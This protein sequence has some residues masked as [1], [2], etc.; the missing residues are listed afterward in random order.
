MLLIAFH[1]PVP[2]N[3]TLGKIPLT[4]TKK[5]MLFSLTTLWF[6]NHCVPSSKCLYIHSVGTITSPETLVYPNAFTKSSFANSIHLDRFNVR[7]GE[8]SLQSLIYICCWVTW[9]LLV[10]MLTKF[11]LEG[12]KGN[13]QVKGSVNK[14][15]KQSKKQR[16]MSRNKII[17]YII[18]III[19]IQ[20]AT[21]Y[22]RCGNVMSFWMY[23][24]DSMVKTCLS[25][26]GFFDDKSLWL[27]PLRLCTPNA[28][29]SA[30]DICVSAPRTSLAYSLF[31]VGTIAERTSYFC[32]ARKLI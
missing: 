23:T 19:N 14:R 15:S 4:S 2:R 24:L 21:G 5:C 31:I 30:T 9:R 6:S 18:I 12:G 29:V 25:V 27:I 16:S 7:K 28:V 3:H 1:P 13:F 11:V 20:W 32:L 17:L 10:V 26:L 8:L 22:K